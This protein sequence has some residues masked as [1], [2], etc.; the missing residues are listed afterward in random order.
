MEKFKDAD[1][2]L[3]HSLTPSLVPGNMLSAAD[4]DK[5][6]NLVRTHHF[7]SVRCN[8]KS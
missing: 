8:E 2:A 3:L 6:R 7:Q 4:V 1:L 5:I